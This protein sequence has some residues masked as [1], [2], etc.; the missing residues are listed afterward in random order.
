MD[1]AG[2]KLSKTFE[3]IK[4]DISF[5]EL[6]DLGKNVTG[7]VLTFNN[8]TLNLFQTDLDKLKKELENIT[9]TAGNIKNSV[10][11]ITSDTQLCPA[12]TAPTC[13]DLKNSINDIVNNINTG[14][15]SL[16]TPDLSNFYIG[17]VSIF[18]YFYDL[19]S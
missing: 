19:L 14:S 16:P 3:V 4:T 11:D 10:D 1:E 8:E 12:L 6:I 17:D 7:K 13:D 18:F 15:A 2:V 5:D 9:A